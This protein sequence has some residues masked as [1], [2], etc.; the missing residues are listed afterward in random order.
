MFSTKSLLVI[1]T[2]LKAVGFLKVTMF[3]LLIMQKITL[4]H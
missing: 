4:V 1:D 2:R 3:L